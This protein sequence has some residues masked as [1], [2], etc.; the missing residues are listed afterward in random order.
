MPR[1]LSVMLLTLLLAGGGLVL[2]AWVG[3]HAG[4]RRA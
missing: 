2:V 1:M 3:Y 4:E